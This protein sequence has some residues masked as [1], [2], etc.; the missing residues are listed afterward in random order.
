MAYWWEENKPNER[1]TPMVQ[2]SAHIRQTK[3]Q[4]TRVIIVHQQVRKA[5]TMRQP[6]N[7]VTYAEQSRTFGQVVNV[8]AS[9]GSR[10]KQLAQSVRRYNSPQMRYKRMA[11]ELSDRKVREE[12]ENMIAKKKA[13]LTEQRARDRV[14]NP[15]IGNKITDAVGNLFRKKKLYD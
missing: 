8:G 13:E 7:Y 4:P 9:V 5:R 1:Q 6:K 12:T 14:N 11:M 15:S 3:M 2:A 10:A